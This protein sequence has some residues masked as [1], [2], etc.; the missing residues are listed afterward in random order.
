[1]TTISIAQ[2]EGFWETRA[3]AAGIPRTPPARSPCGTCPWRLK[4]GNRP[5]EHFPDPGTVDRAW[6]SKRPD[7]AGQGG[8]SDG[9]LVMCHCGC[10][11]GAD[12]LLIAPDQ[13]AL[14]EWR[15]CAGS[16]VTQR[17]EAIR[18]HED[19]TSGVDRDTAVRVARRMGI[20]PKVFLARILTRA[21]LVSRAHPALADPRI[22]HPDLAP[23]APGEFEPDTELRLFDVRVEPLGAAVRER[24]GSVPG[25]E[26]VLDERTVRVAASSAEVA[27]FWL[28]ERIDAP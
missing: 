16:L 24:I 22:G 25:F 4:N 6:R 7:Q 12:G 11:I 23:I 18:W 15:I 27:A 14:P 10:H 5:T 19:G 17:R 28:V 2:E 20:P 13:E 3:E 9:L 1:M 21:D 8:V 26:V